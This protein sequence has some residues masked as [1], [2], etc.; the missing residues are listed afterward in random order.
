MSSYWHLLSFNDLC[1][2]HYICSVPLYIRLFDLCNNTVFCSE[3]SICNLCDP[4]W[5]LDF[6]SFMKKK[7]GLKTTLE[8]ESIINRY[9]PALIRTKTCK[10]GC[11]FYKINLPSRDP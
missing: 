6:W 8:L 10:F 4:E 3:D 5:R 1:I 9:D 7:G 2:G 11:C